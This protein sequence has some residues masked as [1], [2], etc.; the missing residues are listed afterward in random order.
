MTIY[1]G[2]GDDGETDLFDGSRVAKTDP[3]VVAYGT[4]DEL[5]ALVGVANPTGFDDIDERL[6]AVQN[7]LH[8]LQAALANPDESGDTTLGQEPVETLEEWIDDF[9]AQ[10]EP[11][12]QFILPGGGTSGSQLHHA[13]TVCRRAERHVLALA[14][15]D[16]VAES[17]VVYLN[18]LSDWLYVTARVANRRD[19]ISEQNPTY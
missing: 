2:R 7:H 11:Q 15:A 14:E 1:T 17:V 9:E 3:R 8:I 19:G 18:R 10:L 13:R 16:A 12:T 5:N 4:V 6:Q